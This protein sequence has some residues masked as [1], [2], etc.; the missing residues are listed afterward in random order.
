MSQLLPSGYQSRSP[1]RTGTLAGAGLRSTHPA[2][3]DGPAL[4]ASVRK[5]VTTCTGSTDGDELQ[6]L[7][8][9]W[10][11]WSWA[12]E[13]TVARARRACG[14]T[15]RPGLYVWVPRTRIPTGVSA[16]LS[17][18][19]GYVSGRHVHTGFPESYACPRVNGQG[20]S[21]RPFRERHSAGWEAPP[22]GSG[23]LASS[24]YGPQDAG[25]GGRPDVCLARAGLRPHAA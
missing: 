16:C 20:E 10:A 9:D 3:P 25:P 2:G 14:L 13:Q 11:P 1:Q 15:S 12:Q 4:H 21:V 5:G 23:P 19:H 17:T 7:A 24:L 6:D 22:R 8:Q 18:R